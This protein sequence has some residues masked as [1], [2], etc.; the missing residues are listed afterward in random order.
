M[1]LLQIIIIDR[2]HLHALRTTFC[3]YTCGC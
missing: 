2:I 3:S 1:Q